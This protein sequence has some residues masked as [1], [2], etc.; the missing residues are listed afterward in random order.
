MQ[1]VMMLTDSLLIMLNRVLFMNK[2]LEQMWYK[3]EYCTV[4]LYCSNQYS[5]PSNKF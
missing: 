4:V 1:L 5:L 2:E 3:Y